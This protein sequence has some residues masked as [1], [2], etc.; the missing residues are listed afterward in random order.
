MLKSFKKI[1]VLLIFRKLQ[2]AKNE[3]T[4]QTINKIVTKIRDGN[5]SSC[6]VSTG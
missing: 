6:T 1:K 4:N 3:P 5:S 2:N